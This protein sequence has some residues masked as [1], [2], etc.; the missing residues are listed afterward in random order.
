MH[1]LPILQPPKEV[2]TDGAVFNRSMKELESLLKATKKKI[3][4]TK[5]SDAA[6]FHLAEIEDFEDEI[7]AMQRQFIQGKLEESRF[8][9]FCDTVKFY[10]KDIIEDCENVV[11]Q[12]KQKFITPQLTLQRN[13]D[14][15][16]LIEHKPTIG[17]F[18]NPNVR[19]MRS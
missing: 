8:D 7:K 15:S 1:V 18:S 13:R 9:E 3:D 19:P 6:E 14:W 2:V 5:P 4:Q 17:G 16:Q 12:H 10:K 11:A